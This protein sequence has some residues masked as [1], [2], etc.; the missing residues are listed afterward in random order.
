MAG[1]P[2]YGKI[3][4][5]NEREEKEGRVQLSEK[6][7]D[8]NVWTRGKEK[9]GAGVKRYMGEVGARWMRRQVKNG[10]ILERKKYESKERLAEA[11]YCS[12]NLTSTFFT[13]FKI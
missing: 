12:I 3:G 10:G 2:D 11:G 1:K 9:R 5:A 13:H 4:K 8:G 7:F 6:K